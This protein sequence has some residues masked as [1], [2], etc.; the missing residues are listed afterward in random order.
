[1]KSVQAIKAKIA[2]VMEKRDQGKSLSE[3]L[4]HAGVTKEKRS[5]SL[6]KAIVER[7]QLNMKLHKRN[8][9]VLNSVPKRFSS[10][11]FAG[12]VRV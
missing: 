9:P 3:V 1:M 6:V 12:R 10:K 7:A 8:R 11:V 5:M 2:A 4:D